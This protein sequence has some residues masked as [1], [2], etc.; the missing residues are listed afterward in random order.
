MVTSYVDHPYSMDD[1]YE[2]LTLAGYKSIKL[3][4][5]LV[6]TFGIIDFENYISPQL[7]KYFGD[8]FDRN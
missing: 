4:V 8:D 6:V 1:T 2:V 5:K 7:Y 3:V